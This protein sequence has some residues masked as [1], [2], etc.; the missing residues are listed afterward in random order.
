VE[1]AAELRESLKQAGVPPEI[2]NDMVERM[3]P[4]MPGPDATETELGL[5]QNLPPAPRSPRAEAM[6]HQNILG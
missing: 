3:H 1:L 6:A 4:S 5:P 2:I